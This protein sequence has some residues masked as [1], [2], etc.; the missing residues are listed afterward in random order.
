MKKYEPLGN[1]LAALPAEQ[2]SETLT[3]ARIME[4]IGDT[5][6]DSAWNHREWWANQEWGSRAPHWQAAGFK[7]DTVDQQ[8]GIVT[9]RRTGAPPRSRARGGAADQELEAALREI[10][11]RAGTELNERSGRF[12][13]LLNSRGGIGAADESLKPKKRTAGGLN[14]IMELGRPDL[15]LESVVLQRRFRGLFT[16]EQLAEARRRL[17]LVGVIQEVNELSAGRPVGG[18]QDWRKERHNLASS[19]PLFYA[20]PRKKDRDY[21]YHIGGL[22]ELQFNLGFEDVHGTWTF[23]HGVALSLQPTREVRAGDIVGVMLPRI[24]RFNEFMRAYPDAFADLQ[25]WHWTA[26]GRS[27]TYESGPIAGT[28]AEPSSFIMLGAL[29]DPEDV[30]IDWILDDFDR[31]MP[32]Y[33]FVESGTEQMPRLTD[34]ERRARRKTFIFTPGNKGRAPRTSYTRERLRVNKELRHNVLQPKLFDHLEALYGED[35]TSGEQDCGNGTPVDVMVETDK[36]YIYYELKTALSAQLCIREAIGQLMEY[37]YWPGAQEAI[38]LVIVG[39]APFDAEAKKYLA[40]MRK[41]FTLP[42]Y[43]QQF[44]SE[45]GKLL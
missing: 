22:A 45:A 16:R 24:E 39:E 28:L 40:L 30:D 36:G 20:K 11:E 1:Y 26:E 17:G 13:L 4:I 18:L 3:F 15:T 5:L 10:N 35:C 14:R 8:R 44:D 32:L 7:V 41:R 43:Y 19:R 42:F 27:A 29:Q 25:M 37:S 6:P 2:E 23:R 34:G 38:K 12:T 31:L 9:F 33:K 21:I